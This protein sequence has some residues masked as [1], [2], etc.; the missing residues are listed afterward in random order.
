MTLRACLDILRALS[1]GRA[2]FSSHLSFTRKDTKKMKIIEPSVEYWPQ[3]IGMEGVW[4][5]IAKA[6]RVCYQ[7]SVREGKSGEDFVGL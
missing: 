7:S 3:G 1:A 6:T 4:N 2:Q 5:Q